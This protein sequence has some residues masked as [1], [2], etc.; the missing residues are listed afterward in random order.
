M[1]LIM[2]FNARIRTTPD[3]IEINKQ[4]IIAIG[5]LHG[6]REMFWSIMMSSG[7]IELN[8]SG[9]TPRWK[10]KDNI[11]VI[12][13]DTTDSKRQ[14]GLLQDIVI[15]RRLEQHA[16]PKQGIVEILAWPAR[17]HFP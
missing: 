14:K 3:I 16:Y 10:G 12:L 11:V 7:C 6:D 13:G 9:T 2:A 1:Y 4:K 15:K 5:D 8:K 17:E